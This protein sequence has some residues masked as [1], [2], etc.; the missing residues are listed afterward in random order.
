MAMSK[1][2]I[3]GPDIKAEKMNIST[4]KTVIQV[5]FFRI[6]SLFESGTIMNLIEMLKVENM[7]LWNNELASNV[8]TLILLES[9]THDVSYSVILAVGFYN[10][11]LPIGTLEWSEESLLMTLRTSWL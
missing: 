7:L 1:T 11:L 8:D 10:S 9:L 4:S 6:L 3:I 2:M 5:I